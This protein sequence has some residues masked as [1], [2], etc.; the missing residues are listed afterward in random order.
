M[1]T[2]G[3]GI[4]VGLPTHGQFAA[5][6]VAF[7]DALKLGKRRLARE[8]T[9]CYKGD[10]QMARYATSAYWLNYPVAILAVVWC[11]AYHSHDGKD[12]TNE[13]SFCTSGASN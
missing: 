12:E 1:N 7:T 4:R 5:Q 6:L 3:S 2:Y 11:D 9:E 13:C 10:H 8:I